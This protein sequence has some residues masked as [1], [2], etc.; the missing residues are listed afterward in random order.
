DHGIGMSDTQ[1]GRAFERFYRADPSGA[2]PG[3]GLGLSLVKEIV[4]LHDGKV[5]LASK[6]GDGTTIKIWL[7]QVE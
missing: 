3:T 5:E 4:E 6:L 1:L 7:P 2:I